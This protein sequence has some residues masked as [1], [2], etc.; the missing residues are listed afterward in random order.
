MGKGPQLAQN[1]DKIKDDLNVHIDV[2]LE[3]DLAIFHT[4]LATFFILATNVV[5]TNLTFHRRESTVLLCEREA[6]L[7]LHLL[8][9]V[10]GGAAHSAHMII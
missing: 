8:C 9:L 6:H 3:L 1:I 7:S 2:K 5:R 10:R 4:P